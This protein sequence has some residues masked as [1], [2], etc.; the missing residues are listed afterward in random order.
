M[1]VFFELQQKLTLVASMSNIPN[2]PWNIVS[3]RS[4]H[5]ESYIAVLGA[6]NHN[7]DGF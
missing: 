2:L 3:F 5:I 6:K 4:C 7:I 1:A